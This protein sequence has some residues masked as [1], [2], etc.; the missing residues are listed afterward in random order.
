MGSAT[1]GNALV[2]HPDVG[3]VTFTGSH[4]VGISLLARCATLGPKPAICE[5]GGKNPAIVMPSA[6]IDT[7]VS[8]V[9]RAAFSFAGQKCSSNSR[10]IVHRDIADVFIP[11]LLERAAG[12]V[13]GDPKRPDVE[14]GPLIDEAA[15]GRYEA[16]LNSLEPTKVLLDG[17]LI[18]RDELIHGH[19]VR[20]AIVEPSH[21][22]RVW[23]DELFC[24]ILS[25]TKVAS[26]K[27]AL[28]LANATPFGLTAGLFSREQNVIDVFLNGIEAA[29]ANVNRERG[30]TT[31]GWPGSQPFGGWRGSGTTG[32]LSGGPYYLQ[33]YL[34]EQSQLV[35]A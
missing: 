18:D 16:T 4:E 1:A 20:P 24:P 13:I 25:V 31:G 32:K 19:F 9:T 29:V 28:A 8:G 11:A 27:E 6:D 17:G 3:G 7:A 5:M 14:I 26:L 2:D 23:N 10:L 33:Q 35:M 22:S 34:R 12:M 15:V 30:A 21:E